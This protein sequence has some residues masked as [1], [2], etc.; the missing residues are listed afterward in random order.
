MAHLLNI[1]GQKVDMIHMSPVEYVQQIFGEIR[2]PN[3]IPFAVYVFVTPS[4]LMNV[5][6]SCCCACRSARKFKKKLF[7]SIVPIQTGPIFNSGRSCCNLTSKMHA[8]LINCT[9]RR[10]DV[11]VFVL[12]SSV[13][14]RLLV[15][16]GPLSLIKFFIE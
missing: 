13:H 9:N 7:M 5:N 8:S 6:A 14:I 10:P 1:S 16:I 12:A 2:R 11:I 4:L 3:I 15:P